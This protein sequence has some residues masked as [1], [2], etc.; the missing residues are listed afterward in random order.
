MRVPSCSNIYWIDKGRSLRERVLYS[1][2]TTC[3]L[4]LRFRVRSPL[5]FILMWTR[6]RSSCQKSIVNALPKV[7][8][9]LRVLRF[10]PTGKVDRGG[11]YVIRAHSNWL[12][13]L[14][15]PCPCG[16]AKQNKIK[17]VIEL[18][19]INKASLV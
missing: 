8:D 3:L 13:L 4:P 19:S 12:T 18:S 1:G 11:G 5:R 16:E 17:K 14:W 15:L 7:V 2:Q 6:I 9:F 10:P